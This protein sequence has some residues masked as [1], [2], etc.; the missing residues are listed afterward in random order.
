MSSTLDD[1]RLETR[2]Y[3]LAIGEFR[4]DAQEA[5]NGVS[6]PSARDLFGEILVVISGRAYHDTGGSEAGLAV[7][8]VPLMATVM[9]LIA[10][11]G[12]LAWARRRHSQAPRPRNEKSHWP[13]CQ[14]LTHCGHVLNATVEMRTVSGRHMMSW[15]P[16]LS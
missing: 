6:G 2:R 16:G 4:I 14:R 9:K 1:I 5:R 15:R 12:G 13:L 11:L 7:A 10:V 8:P 3:V